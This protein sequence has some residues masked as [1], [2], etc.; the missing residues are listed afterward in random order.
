MK[1]LRQL[2]IILAISFI[3]EMMSAS[4]PGRVP[5]SI[6]GLVL[7]FLAFYFKILKV[8]HVRDAAAFFIEVMPV[9]FIP[10]GVAILVAKEAILSNLIPILT[11]TLVSTVVVIAS[12][13]LVAQVVYSR[14]MER[15]RKKLY[16][17]NDSNLNS[18]N[19]S[20]LKKDE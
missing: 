3:A 6:Y 10:A 14:K 9:V 2:T 11:I 4:L 13:G 1:Y 18:D 8:S 7:M 12:S 17:N 19:N 15:E 5:G 20:N 16:E